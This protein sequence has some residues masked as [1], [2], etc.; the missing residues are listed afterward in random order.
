MLYARAGVE[1]RAR[2]RR[3]LGEARPRRPAAPPRAV[4]L[5][6]RDLARS[7]P[8]R[9]AHGMTEL[10]EAMNGRRGVLGQVCVGHE[11]Y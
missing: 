9:V 4:A 8:S 3:D 10:E 7:P 2:P 5:A 11:K 1:G 6:S